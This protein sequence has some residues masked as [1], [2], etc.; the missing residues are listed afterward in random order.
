MIDQNLDEDSVLHMDDEEEDASLA[1]SA[2]ESVQDPSHADSDSE[3]DDDDEHS[4]HDDEDDGDE[5]DDED[6]DSENEGDSDDID[7]EEE[8]HE[9]AYARQ[10]EEEAFEQELYYE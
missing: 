8:F 4:D 6:L 5:D 1:F 10:L 7:S 3:N 9:E 2:K